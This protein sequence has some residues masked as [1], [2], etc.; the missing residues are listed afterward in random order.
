MS[1]FSSVSPATGIA[2]DASPQYIDP[3]WWGKHLWISID[4]VATAFD[5]NDIASKEFVL[6]FFFS[7]QG[8]I[9]CLECRAHYQQYFETYPISDEL[10]S[11]SSLFQWILRLKNKV[12]ER[13]QLPLISWEEYLSRLEDQF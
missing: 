3:K 9:P 8:V 7:L 10:D 13:L 6:Y 4:A 12:N 2:V 1:S 5:P 11:K